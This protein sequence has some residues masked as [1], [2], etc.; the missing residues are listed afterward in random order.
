MA[1]KN[2][3]GFIIV[4]LV[5]IVAIVGIVGLVFLLNGAASTPTKST[6]GYE[7]QLYDAQGNLVG[8]PVSR[9]YCRKRS[10]CWWDRSAGGCRCE[11]SGS[12][13]ESADSI[14]MPSRTTTIVDR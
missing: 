7:L 14:Y 2:D 9:S 5:G 4:A 11:G 6:A 3:D 13:D 8:D 12:G 1:E 10:D